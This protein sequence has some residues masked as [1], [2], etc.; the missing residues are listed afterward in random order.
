MSPRPVWN[1]AW[2]FVFTAAGLPSGS[3]DLV[4]W[5][6]AWTRQDYKKGKPLKIFCFNRETVVKGYVGFILRGICRD[7]DVGVARLGSQCVCEVGMPISGTWSGCLTRFQ[8][9]LFPSALS[10]SCTTWSIFWNIFSGFTNRL[11]ITDNQENS[12]LPEP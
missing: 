4:L 12:R 8:T 2:A 10:S 3:L 9:S 7:D 1:L 11:T 6:G 5:L